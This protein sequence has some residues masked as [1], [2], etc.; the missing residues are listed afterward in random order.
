M[1]S[2][3]DNALV[4]GKKF[5]ARI[6]LTACCAIV[7]LAGCAPSKA[8]IDKSA[9]GGIYWPG[10]PEKPRIKYMWSISL[11]SAGPEG[12]RSLADLLTG[13]TREDV[14]D[15]RTSNVLMRPYSVFVDA[16]ERLCVADPGGLRVTVI[17]LATA[18]V[19]NIT[20]AGKEQLASPVG[21]VSDAAGRIFVSD[22]ELGKVFVFDRKGKYLYRFQG[23]FKRPTCLAIDN[24]RS[25]VYVSDTLSHEIFIY[26]LDGKRL[27]SIGRRGSLPGEFNFPTHLFVDR[28]GL[29]YVTDAMNFRVEIFGP[30]GKFIGTV[31]RLGD[32]RADL[33]KP[34]GVAADSEGHIYVVDSIHDT[35]KIYDRNGN[36]L[37]FFGEKGTRIGSLWLPSGIYIDRNDMIY[38]ADTYNMRIQAF[39]FLKGGDK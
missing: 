29:L 26:D 11:L 21:V 38:V 9:M 25:R 24:E 10:P 12:R 15:P 20:E 32:A 31:G 2:G 37:L 7:L 17:D 30:D 22:S 35:V 39:Q 6:L 33:D 18:D 27:G 4:M 1:A 19:F 5:F 3:C 28:N 14:T 13:S 8:F 23:D 34:K 36:L 16:K